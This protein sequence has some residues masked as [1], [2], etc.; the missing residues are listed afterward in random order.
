ME[1]AYLLDMSARSLFITLTLLVC[2]SFSF[3]CL[4]RS[5]LR[6][7]RVGGHKAHVQQQ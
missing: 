6:R 1:F 3:S 4:A 7:A 2:V 5:A